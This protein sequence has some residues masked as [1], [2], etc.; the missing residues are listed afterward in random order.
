MT[1]IAHE[2]AGP[3]SREPFRSGARTT[4]LNHQS[5]ELDGAKSRSR[6]DALASACFHRG[7]RTE[8]PQRSGPPGAGP[9]AAHT[10]GCAEDASRATTC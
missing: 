5:A 9:G 3:I 1:H 6:A 8:P 10:I 4:D 2:G 7:L